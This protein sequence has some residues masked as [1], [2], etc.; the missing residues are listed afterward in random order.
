MTKRRP[1][2]KAQ[3]QDLSDALTVL[4]LH[5]RRI[6]EMVAMRGADVSGFEETLD[7]IRAVLDQ[8]IKGEGE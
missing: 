8:P 6:Y 2:S 5:E 4:L 3:R 1:L 7:A